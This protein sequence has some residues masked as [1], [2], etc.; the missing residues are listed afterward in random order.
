MSI[1]AISIAREFSLDI[2]CFGAGQPQL[3]IH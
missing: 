3:D 1:D 2:K